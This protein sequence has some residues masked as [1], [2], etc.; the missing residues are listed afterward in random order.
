MK[1]IWTTFVQ[2][3]GWK[4]ISLKSVRIKQP[5]VLL[6]GDSKVQSDDA[7]SDVSSEEGSSNLKFSAKRKEES[8]NLQETL[9][10]VLLRHQNFNEL[11]RLYQDKQVM[12]KRI[13]PTLE[14]EDSARGDGLL[15]ELYSLFW[16][17]FIQRNC[18]GS[19][20]FVLTILPQTS[21][22]FD[23]IGR[24]I[25]HQFVQC[26]VFPV[27]LARASVHPILFGKVDEDCLIESF[28]NLLPPRQR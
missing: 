12:T 11:L 4:I 22:K 15:R 27:K 17:D 7:E 1:P 14:G 5:N 18:G 6:S 25:T 3:K 8:E 26:A 10:N 16:D 24:I 23:T 13:I 20:Q 9:Y 28:F 19:D 21:D 2:F